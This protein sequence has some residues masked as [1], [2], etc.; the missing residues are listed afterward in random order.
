MLIAFLQMLLESIIDARKMP[1][2]A[3]NSQRLRQ[4][5]EMAEAAECQG[6]MK[7]CCPNMRRFSQW[8]D[9]L[10]E[11]QYLNWRMLLYHLKD[12]IA[13]QD[14]L[15]FRRLHRHAPSFLFLYFPACVDVTPELQAKVLGHLK[16]TAATMTHSLESKC[17]C[18]VTSMDDP[19]FS[20]S[21]EGRLIV[22]PVSAADTHIGAIRA[23][24]TIATIPCLCS[25][26]GL[27]DDG[28]FP[29]EITGALAPPPAF[30]GACAK[31]LDPD[32][33]AELPFGL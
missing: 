7:E 29:L 10:I 20:R 9:C 33:E 30:G 13:V 3:I 4:L 5:I 17:P 23:Q 2:P 22:M 11:G 16:A 18:R 1:S 15:V 27:P 25:I 31:D 26:M 24:L 32:E 12:E 19:E 14:T 8:L 21:E 6:L 28:Y